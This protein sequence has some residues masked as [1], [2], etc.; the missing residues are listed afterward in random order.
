MIIKILKNVTNDDITLINMFIPA[1]TEYLL[2]QTMWA[3]VIQNG[4]IFTLIN[5]GSLVINDG[6]NDLTI[7]RATKLIYTMQESVSNFSFRRIKANRSILIE[8]DQQMRVYGDLKIDVD[9][10]IVLYGEVVVKSI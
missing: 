5:S 6:T 4:Y 2:E 3:K 9:G 8:D 7:P 1:Q 10:E